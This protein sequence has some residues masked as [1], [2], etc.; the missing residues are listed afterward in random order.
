LIGEE[1]YAVGA[2]LKTGP[3]H[4]ASLR[5]QD[6]LRWVIILAIL[7]GSILKFFEIL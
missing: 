1:L 4:I 7:L 2:Y 6:L 3:I 5:A